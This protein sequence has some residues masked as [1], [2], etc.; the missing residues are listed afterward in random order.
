MSRS[1]VALV[2]KAEI[3]VAIAARSAI[4]LLSIQVT[5]IC[6]IINA[7]TL[8]SKRGDSVVGLNTISLLD[9]FT[10]QERFFLL[11]VAQV[12]AVTK[13]KKACFALEMQVRFLCG[14]FLVIVSTNC[15]KAVVAEVI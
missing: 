6:L 5:G 14:L 1:T 2:T 12:F 15:N 8:M 3:V 10:F 4:G 7:S 9:G 11:T 13:S